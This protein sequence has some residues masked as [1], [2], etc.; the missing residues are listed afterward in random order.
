MDT[1]KNQFYLV[2]LIVSLAVCGVILFRPN[3]VDRVLGLFGLQNRTSVIS[4]APEW[5]SLTVNNPQDNN[6]FS[7]GITPAGDLSYSNDSDGFA[8]TGSSPTMLQ[9]L[10]PQTPMQPM[11]GGSGVEPFQQYGNQFDNATSGLA[12]DEGVAV[13]G[14]NRVAMPDFSGDF[15]GLAESQSPGFAGYVPGVPPIESPP[16][17]NEITIQFG[18]PTDPNAIPNTNPTTSAVNDY[19]V[20]SGFSLPSPSTPAASNNVI[21]FAD[22]AIPVQSGPQPVAPVSNMSLG[23]NIP[24]AEASVVM[25]DPQY[26]L[27]FAD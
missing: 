10:I 4:I 16:V 2:I 15:S 5:E 14:T 23:G 11:F 6:V 17:T 27:G 25:P 3:M 18:G 13:S 26:D 22:Y 19:H 8:V 24:V 7:L 20:G 12:F 9:T 1:L 21:G